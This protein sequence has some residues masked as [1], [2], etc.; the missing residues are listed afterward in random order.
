MGGKK[1]TK[2]VDSIVTWKNIKSGSYA[3]IRKFKDRRN[4]PY[5]NVFPHDTLIAFS[6]KDAYKQAKSYMRKH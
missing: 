2:N 5:M 1:W 6:R 3:E 4:H